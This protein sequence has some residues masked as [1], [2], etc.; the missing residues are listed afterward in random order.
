MTTK[1]TRSADIESVLNK[2]EAIEASLIK[3]AKL[4]G[5]FATELNA[6]QK[7]IDISDVGQVQ[8]M[9][10][11]LTISQVGGQR[12][13]YRHQEMETAQKAL[14]G[15]SQSFASK[16]FAPRLRDMRARALLKVEGKLHQHFP[17]KEALRTAAHQST[18]LS[19]LAPIEAGAVMSSYGT[20]DAM[21][22]AKILLAAWSAADAFE[23][24]HLG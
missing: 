10:T 24:K 11:L 12:R 9:T 14:I 7:S 13:T 21:R 3:E 17:E 6:L 16:V 20:D 18:E 15:S 5:D 22:Q 23:Q 8:R 2:C 4:L 19:E 1:T